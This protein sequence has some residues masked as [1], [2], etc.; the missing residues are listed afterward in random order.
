MVGAG[1][2]GLACARRLDE[3]GVLVDVFDKGRAPGGRICTKVEGDRS[4]D[5]G[6]QFI[7]AR[8]DLF[9]AQ[10]SEW[11]QAGTLGPWA[12]LEGSYL[13][14]PSMR[15]LGEAMTTG[16]SVTSSMTV[17]KVEAR[18]GEHVLWGRAHGENVRE[19]GS[20]HRV[21]MATPAPQAVALVKELLG[22][23]SAVEYLPCWALLLTYD[24]KVDLP[25]VLR[26]SD[27]YGFVQCESRKPGRDATTERWVV[28]MAAEWSRRHLEESAEEALVAALP[29]LPAELRRPSAMRAHRWRYASL[30]SW[31]GKSFV[32]VG[33]VSACGDGLLGPR[34]ELAWSSGDALGQHLCEN[35]T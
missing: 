5:H 14:I 24:T 34:V 7:R 19:L 23:L 2:A 17:T 33:R 4:W 26:G 25:A 10:L 16:L 11:T 35:R 31:V 32:E 29:Q 13:G 21:V 9:A 22:P 15:S 8:G 30:E 3:A 28:H 6:A 1:I 18:E 27:A 12:N 20:Y